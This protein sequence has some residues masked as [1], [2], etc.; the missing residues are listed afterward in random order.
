MMRNNFKIEKNLNNL[1]RGNWVLM[2]GFLVVVFNLGF[3]GAVNW[4]DTSIIT[5]NATEDSVEYYNLSSNLD[6]PNNGNLTFAIDSDA[7]VTW[8]LDNGT[9]LILDYIDVSEWIFLSNVSTGNLTINATNNNQTGSFTFG[10]Q[11]VGDGSDLAPFTF[12]ITSV[13]DPPIFT[14]LTNGGFYNFTENDDNLIIQYNATDEEG[15]WDGTGY[16]LNFSSNIT[17]CNS[18]INTTDC[19]NLFNLSLVGNNSMKLN[20]SRTNDYVGYYNM[21]FWVNDSVNQTEINVTFEIVNVNDAPNITFACDNNRNMTEDDIM[22]CWVN[23]TDIDESASLNFSIFSDLEQFTFNNSLTTYNY[24]CAGGGQCNASANVTFVL[25]DSA[26]GNWSVNISVTDTGDINTVGWFNFSFFVNNTEDLVYIDDVLDFEVSGNI[27]K[28]IT[29]YDD[30]FLVD[31]S[32]S[33]V[34]DEQLNFTSSNSTFVYFIEGVSNRVGTLSNLQE[35]ADNYRAVTAYIDWNAMNASMVDGEN[36]TINISVVDTTGNSNWTEFTITFNNNS[37]PIWNASADYNFTIDEDNSSWGG[38]N[39]SDGYVSDV[40]GENITFYY[41]ND[42]QFD[43]FNLSNSSGSWIINFTPLDVDVGYHDITLYASDGNVNV[44]QQFNF[45]VNNIADTPS[46][47][48][49]GA[50]NGTI[51][52]AIVEGINLVATEDTE[53]NFTLD[54]LDDDFLIPDGQKTFYDESIMVNVTA[55]NYSSIEVDLFNFSSNGA[56]S[57]HVYYNVNFT[58]TEADN[59][60]IFVEITDNSSASVNRTFYLNVSEVSDAPVLIEFDNESLTIHDYINFTVNATDDE[61]DDNTLNYSIANL[62]VGSPNLTIGKQNGS[63]EFNMSSNSSYAGV[64]NY[65]ITVTDNDTQ[66][67]SQIFYLYVYG[68]ATLESPDL[69]SSFNLTEEVTSVLN[70]TINHSVADNLTYEFWIDSI[71]CAYNDS[72]DCTYGDLVLRET[73]SSFGDGTVYNWSFKPN[74]TDET[75]GNYKNLTVRVYPNA[76]NFTSTQLAAVATNFTFKLNITHTNA[77]P[78][79]YNNFTSISGYYGDT[80]PIN[81]TLTDNF[82]DYDYLDSYYL[83][84]VTFTIV[85]AQGTSSEI[86]AEGIEPTDRLSSPF[87]NTAILDWSLQLYGKGALS[88]QLTISINDSSE[89]VTGTP[90]IATFTA[91]P[92]TVVTTPSSGGSSS[93]SSGRTKIKHFSIK[94]IIPR[95][96]VISDMNYIDVPFSIINNGQTDLSGIN[97]SSLVKFNDKFNDDIKISLG[98]NYIDMLKIGES[99]N[100]TM[101]I[102]A[103]THKS[104]K[105]R[106]TIVADVTAPKFSDWGEFYIELQKTNESKAEQLLIFT[107]KLIA[108]NP[109]CLEL[110]ETLRMAEAEFSNGEFSNAIEFAMRAIESCEDS[111]EA[112]EQIRYPVAGFV[113][114][115]FY[116]ISFLTL[117]IFLFGFIFYVYRRVKF[118]KYK[119]GEYI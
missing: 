29:A 52:V 117:A 26:V 95:D 96:I 60:I 89:N 56:A 25:N 66:T 61:D 38:V 81:I 110:T 20:I 44:T 83:Q 108:E 43:N 119:V 67:D 109:E 39:L 93:G 104:G 22:S 4:N 21:T 45:T 72:S 115:N 5:Y 106:A 75:Y 70:F 53:I 78:V 11:F 86:Y 100:F 49:F 27:S 34:K 13:N 62:T 12:N 2:F 40:D 74:Y 64:W 3:V 107:E 33:A 24:S 14:E 37:A 101:R 111:I 28:T 55:W 46:I 97:L 35:D 84:E 32:Q 54:I 88:E 17:W 57:E 23:A 36:I 112:N 105:Y 76:T 113:K 118:N 82:R 103:D 69:D 30:D 79:E 102:S 59:Y 8:I 48:P 47:G 68:N 18:S 87:N 10:I 65:S 99:Q 1:G 114:D 80:T 85:S 50:N 116:Y 90:F 71:T 16:P 7:N 63:V 31:D 15:D 19:N 41:T 94:L 92:V 42:M 51:Y 77:P 98:I 73:T 58:P 6:G 91:P 9:A